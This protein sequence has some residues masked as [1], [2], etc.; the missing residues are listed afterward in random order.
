MILLIPFLI[1]KGFILIYKVLFRFILIFISFIRFLLFFIPW[2]RLAAGVFAHVLF[3]LSFLSFLG[4]AYLACPES[5]T[6]I[7]FPAGFI[8]P[9]RRTPQQ[10]TFW[11]ESSTFSFRPNHPPKN[12]WTLSDRVGDGGGCPDTRVAFFFS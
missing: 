5:S 1:F 6:N 12:P 11:R 8:W 9:A 7:P 4:R 2:Q 3:I 10:S